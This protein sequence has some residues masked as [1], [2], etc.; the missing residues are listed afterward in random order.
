MRSQS[1]VFGDFD[2]FAWNRQPKKRDVHKKTPAKLSKK[3]PEK[4]QPNFQGAVPF[5]EDRD[6]LGED[7]I[8]KIFE[9]FGEEIDP[10]DNKKQKLA[11]A[12]AKKHQANED[13]CPPPD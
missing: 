1:R 8:N 9:N 3:L 2:T 10:E 6:E 12:E 4:P 13:I 5:I 7:E 11:D